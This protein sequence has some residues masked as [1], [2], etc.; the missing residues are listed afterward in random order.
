MVNHTIEVAFTLLLINKSTPTDINECLE[1]I[2]SC[3]QICV[4]NAG[5]Y[6]CQCNSGF[7]LDGDLRACNGMQTYYH[8]HAYM[9]DL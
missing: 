3:A 1:G 9:H 4:N 2:H 5:S 7:R 6:T 8:Q